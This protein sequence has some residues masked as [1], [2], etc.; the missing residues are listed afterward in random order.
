MTFR[1]ERPTGRPAPLIVEVP[2][3][4]IDVP[5]ELAPLLAV[6]ARDVARDADLYV[7]ELFHRAPAHGAVL[8][9]AQTSR[10]VVDLNRFEHDVD[11]AA[12]PG[13]PTARPHLPR[14]LIWRETTDG[15]AVL[16]RPLSP[17]ELEARLERYYHPYHRALAAEIN[18]VRA[19]FGFVV[20]L[21]AHSMPS[22]GRATHTDP[23]VRRADVVPGTRGRT[24]AHAAVI[25][26]V[27]THFRAAG[28][29]VRHD[30]PYRGGATTARWGQPHEGIHAIQVELNRALYMDEAALARR[31]DAFRWLAS[32]CDALVAR[33]ADLTVPPTAA[34]R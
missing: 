3:A 34:P 33:L 32:L 4:G 31:G 6:E 29:S 17:A 30:D 12:V 25:D 2:H 15:R 27:D 23:A 21:S 14:G 10:Y 28:L 7:D 22:V 20:L 16:R 11:A 5:A 24:T 1:L 8:L 18:A 13:L 9:T 26:A 19:R